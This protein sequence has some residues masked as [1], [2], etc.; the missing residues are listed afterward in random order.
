MLPEV[1]CRRRFGGFWRASARLVL[2]FFS[3]A[4][5][6]FF[7]KL[8]AFLTTYHAMPLDI[9]ALS[10]YQIRRFF[11]ENASVT[12][13]QCDAMAQQITGQP[14]TATASQ[15]GA[16]YTVEGGEVV[17][18]F[19]VPDSALDMDMLQCIEQAYQGFAPQHEYR[20][21]LGQVGVYAMN[22]VRGVCMYLARDEL[23][24][25]NYRLL[26]R[27]I[28]DY[29]RLVNLSPLFKAAKRSTNLVGADS[30]P[31]RTITRPTG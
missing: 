24:S 29:A 2:V 10:K 28:D 23:Q 6:S 17:V 26:R 13:Q 18:Q 25:D 8:P 11:Q 31:R 7:L 27:T 4:N 30:S 22:N 20:G 15:G 1:P 12:Q 5:E 9:S 19:R 21:R 3:R 14:V 16:S